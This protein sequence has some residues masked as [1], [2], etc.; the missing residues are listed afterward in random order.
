[1]QIEPIARKRLRDDII[2]RLT[3]MIVSGE[4]DGDRPLKEIDIAKRLGVSR[5]PLRE[6]L[7]MLERDGLVVSAVNKGFRVAALSEDRVREIYPILGTLEGLAVRESGPMMRTQVSELRELNIEL[8]GTRNKRRRHAIDREFHDTLCAMC[9]NRSLVEMVRS[10]WQHAQRYDGAVERG[11]A[12]PAGSLREHVAI[13]DAIARGD[14]VD[15]AAQIEDHWRRG[16]FTVIAWL[17][18]RAVGYTMI[19]LLVLALT[20]CSKREAALDDATWGYFVDE[21]KI[22]LLVEQWSREQQPRTVAIEHVDVLGL[23]GLTSDQTVVVSGGLVRA[24]G[25]SATVAVPPDALVVDGRGKTLMPGLVDMHTHT[26]L[27][28]GHYILDLAN[29]VTSVR[30]MDG[31]PYLL[32]QRAAERANRLLVPNLYVAGKILASKP[33][34]WYAN[35]VTTP[36]E[37]R[38]VVRAQKADG[39]EF[40]K[41]H[42]IVLP[43]VYDAI[44]AEARAQG[45]DVVGHIPHDIPI[46]HALACGQRTFEHFK[47]YI[48]DHDLTLTSEDYVGV[49][50]GAT[51]WNTPTFYMYRAHVRGDAARALLELPEMRY[52]PA[53]DRARWRA[54][55]NEPAKPVQLNVLPLS[56]KIFKDLIGIHARFLAGTDSGGG[57]PYHVPGFSLHEELRIMARNGMPLE[58]VLRTATIEPALAMRRESELG[59]IAVG[60]RAD[61]MLLDASP[62]ADLANLERIAGVMVRGIWLPRTTL[63]HMLDA[64]AAIARGGPAPT[65][66]DLTRTLD[67]LE[68]LRARGYVLRDHFLGWLRYRLEHA[69]MSVQRPLF[70]GIAALAPDDD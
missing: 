48:N 9:P 46:A 27:S 14:Y 70:A 69:G 15:A 33:L 29:G 1:M 65:R 51:V 32:R 36:D 58:D 20:S 56:V 25:S 24:L 4:L 30:E 12:D 62:L 21:T 54:L 3:R 39:Y 7:L 37:A 13:T 67:T 59:A 47:G 6:A 31:M 19:A 66:A 28:E 68:Q 57:Y 41:V 44:C 34:E 35:V 22:D 42:N 64:I 43:D 52:V 60:K 18:D 49:T 17:R 26:Q 16:V 8:R 2:Q 11:M 10:L 38:A 40:I 23:P 63:D 55:A 5:T 61:L 45:L 50:R 53:R